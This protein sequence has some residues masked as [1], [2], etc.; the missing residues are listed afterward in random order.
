MLL[1]QM[2]KESSLDTEFVVT[3]KQIES[4]STYTLIGLLNTKALKTPQGFPSIWLR[5]LLARNEA[6][7]LGFLARLPMVSL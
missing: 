4:E 6:E 2:Y 3:K 5:F 1:K 7:L